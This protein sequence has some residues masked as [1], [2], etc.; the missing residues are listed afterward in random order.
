VG[1]CEFIV[2]QTVETEAA[3]A[4][5]LP[6]KQFAKLRVTKFS[7]IS[8]RSIIEWFRATYPG[9]MLDTWY[10]AKGAGAGGTDRMVAYTLDPDHLQ[11]Y[12]PQEFEQLP[13]Q[14]RNL[15]FVVPCHARIG[16]V[17]VYYPLS[18]SYGDGI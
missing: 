1:I 10:K 2:D 18:M 15:E 9:V 6:R 11:G 3:N 12:I 4:I 13:V 17:A 14:E 5:V 8:D 7:N 16:G